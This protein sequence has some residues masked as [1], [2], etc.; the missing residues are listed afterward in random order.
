MLLGLTVD[1][2]VM[3]GLNVLGKGR[4]WLSWTDWCN[5]LFGTN[6]GRNTVYHAPRDED[7]V[8]TFRMDTTQDKRRQ[9]KS[10]LQASTMMWKPSLDAIPENGKLA[11]PRAKPGPCRKVGNKIE[12]AGALRTAK[13]ST[14]VEERCRYDHV[15]DVFSAYA[16]TAFGF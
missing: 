13:P 15:R 7:D 12:K 8:S 16:T 10:N 6:L 2:P 11:V 1:W 14:A 3:V 9:R 5:E 4:C